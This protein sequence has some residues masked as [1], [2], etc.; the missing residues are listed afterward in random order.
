MRSYMSDILG[1]IHERWLKEAVNVNLMGLR[2]H[3]NVIQDRMS[4]IE[5]CEIESG[6]TEISGGSVRP[7]PENHAADIRSCGLLSLFD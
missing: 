2:Q 4:D 3:S 6:A 1:N 5:I 7:R